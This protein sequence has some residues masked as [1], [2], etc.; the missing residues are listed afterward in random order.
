MIL[1]ETLIPYVPQS[2]VDSF[3][4]EIPL[5]HRPVLYY[6]C[7]FGILEPLRKRW[8]KRCRLLFLK[9]GYSPLRGQSLQKMYWLLAFRQALLYKKCNFGARYEEMKR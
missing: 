5:I 8:E 2:P 4:N 1:I 9:K 7:L 3:L 6:I